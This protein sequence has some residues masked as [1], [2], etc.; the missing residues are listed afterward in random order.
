MK[1][2]GNDKYLYTCNTLYYSVNL[3]NLYHLHNWLMTI[4]N[5][6]T[7]EIQQ[8]RFVLSLLFPHDTR[9]VQQMSARQQRDL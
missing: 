7:Y 2:K 5:F 8:N 1:S 6:K 4:K 9:G 3:L